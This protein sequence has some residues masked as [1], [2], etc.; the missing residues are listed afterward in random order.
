MARME[1]FD[2]GASVNGKLAQQIDDIEIAQD[3]A[4]WE[5]SRQ[6]WWAAQDVLSEQ[7]LVEEGLLE[8][9]S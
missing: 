9:P 3:C 1:N 5:E 8:W 4:A 6:D 7:E 2:G